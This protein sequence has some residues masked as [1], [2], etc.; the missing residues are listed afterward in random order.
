MAGSFCGE[1]LAGVRTGRLPTLAAK[2]A[3]L[4]DWAVD[5]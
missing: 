4:L 1:V 3:S 2:S 5:A